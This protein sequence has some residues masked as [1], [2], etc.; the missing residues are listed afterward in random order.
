MKNSKVANTSKIYQMAVIGVMTA[1]LCILGPLSLPI[2]LVPISFTNL[3]IF[4]TLYTLGMKKGTISTILYLFLGFAGLPVFSGFTSGPPKLLGPTGGY[5]IGFVFMALIAGFFIDR[6]S[7][8]WYLCIVGMVLGTA[9]CYTSGTVWLAYQANI[10]AKAALAAGVF[11]FILGDLSKIIL[12]AY[13]GPKI[14]KHLL[15]ANFL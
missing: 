1:V 9:V 11:P 8:Q 5:L 13:I 6:F 10:S 2:G 15:Q 4:I 12:S 3:A 7:N 14:Q